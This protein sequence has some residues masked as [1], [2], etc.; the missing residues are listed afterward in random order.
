MN[1][2]VGAVKTGE[3][4][5]TGTKDIIPKYIT[6]DMIAMTALI[7]SIVYLED[8]FLLVFCWRFCFFVILLC[9]LDIIYLDNALDN[10]LWLLVFAT[11]AK[12]KFRFLKISSGQ[13]FHIIKY[14]Y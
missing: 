7:M 13:N 3:L 12:L 6:R 10:W 5:F 9:A 8:F 2:L 4:L 11:I 1:V 14:I